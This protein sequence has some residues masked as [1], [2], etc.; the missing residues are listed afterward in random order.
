MY[1]PTTWR[2]RRW[3]L[4][5]LAGTMNLD[6]TR[7]PLGTGKDGKPVYLKDIWPTEQ[8]IQQTMLFSVT[9]EAFR[10][11]YSSVFAGDSHKAAPVP[12]GD[13][14]EWEGRRPTFASRHFSR[15]CR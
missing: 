13:R 6:V 9:S 1:A 8:E 4:P 5:A 11:Q 12:T 15:G 2:R 10:Q 3:W 14:F 7:E